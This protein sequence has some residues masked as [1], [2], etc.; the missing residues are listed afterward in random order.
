MVTVQHGPQGQPLNPA[1]QQMGPPPQPQP[2]QTGRPQAPGE[3]PSLT[4][5]Q[6]PTPTQANKPAPKGK[7]GKERP[8]RNRTKGGP[9]PVTPNAS[10]PPTPTT[11]ITPLAPSFN[12]HAPPQAAQ[13]QAA[14]PQPPSQQPPPDQPPPPA[15]PSQ[16]A[17]PPSAFG[18]IDAA[19]AASE[20]WPDDKW[21]GQMP[22]EFSIG[23]TGL[24]DFSST[25]FGM[26][27]EDIINYGE[28]LNDN[29]GLGIELP[30]W[31]EELG[32]PEA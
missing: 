1:Q 5:A 9:A 20:L 12:Q 11:P 10:E 15:P 4:S 21:I 14:Q 23:N 29:E 25:S 24:A 8:K 27:D 7:P 32:A 22:M 3:S 2:T 16:D 28:F 30:L 6:P 18:T 19:D 31:G 17:A 26:P 13:A